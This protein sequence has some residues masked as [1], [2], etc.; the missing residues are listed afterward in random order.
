MYTLLVLKLPQKLFPLNATKLPGWYHP[1]FKTTFIIGARQ[2]LILFSPILDKSV[3]A[4]IRLEKIQTSY[5]GTVLKHQILGPPTLRYGCRKGITPC[6]HKKGNFSA[7]NNILALQGS[8]FQILLQQLLSMIF[9]FT[10]RSQFE[11][12][13][14]LV[15]F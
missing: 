3:R 14:I 8:D 7:I 2:S 6:R 10:W 11:K 12:I 13:N 1:L 15:R 5:P 9:T 4:K